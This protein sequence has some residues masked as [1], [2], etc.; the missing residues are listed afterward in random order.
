MNRRTHDSAVF[1][2][3]SA[4]R[5]RMLG[6]SRSAE[7]V[8]QGEGAA[9]PTTGPRAWTAEGGRGALRRARCLPREGSFETPPDL[10]SEIIVE[11]QSGASSSA[12]ER[13]AQRGLAADSMRA[14]VEHRVRHCRGRSERVLGTRSTWS[15]FRHAVARCRR[16]PAAAKPTLGGRPRRRPRAEDAGRVAPG[17]AGASSFSTLA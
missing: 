1:I 8:E 4:H 16:A 6:E 10:G 9:Q 2:A 17:S 13:L 12:S 14:S 3:P 15:A 7:A 5:G 11:E